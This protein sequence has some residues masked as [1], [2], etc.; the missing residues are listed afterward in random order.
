MRQ[1]GIAMASSHRYPEA[2]KLFHDAIDNEG[3]SAGQGNRWTIWYYFACVAT[4][5]NDSNNA[6]QY[7]QEAV[8]RG[9]KDAN[10][11]MADDDLKNLHP[12]PKF[13]Q[14]VAALKQP[15]TKLQAQK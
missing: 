1:L 13:Q 15:P 9:Y 6:V 8:N 4:A 12:N 3:N 11:L 2:S 5:A 10:G 7:L 14:L